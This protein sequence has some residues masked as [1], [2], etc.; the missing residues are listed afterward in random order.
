MVI[1]PIAPGA[2]TR[3]DMRLGV[4]RR[5]PAERTHFWGSSCTVGAQVRV[6]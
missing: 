6:P 1:R 3:K 5:P 4:P 2:V